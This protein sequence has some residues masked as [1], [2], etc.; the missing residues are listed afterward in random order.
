RP[1]R[2]CRQS[3]LYNRPCIR[4]GLPVRPPPLANRALQNVYARLSIVPL[5]ALLANE[6]GASTLAFLLAYALVIESGRWQ[7]RLASLI[8][9]PIVMLLWRTAYTGWGFGVRSFVGY[10]DPGY[11]PLAFLKSLL[12][13]MNGLLGG[14][15]T[16]IPPETSFA[17]SPEM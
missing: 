3:W 14:Q 13:R 12:P 16:G 9:A 7:A 8:P 1:R 11:T 15:L 10:I 5:A 17:L 6:G 2:L 4:F